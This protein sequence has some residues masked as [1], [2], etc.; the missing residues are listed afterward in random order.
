MKKIFFLSLLILPLV[1]CENP[2]EGSDKKP[3]PIVSEVEA[4]DFEPAISDTTLIYDLGEFTSEVRIKCPKTAFRGTILVLQGWNFPN[5]SWSDST[6][7]E[8]L[9]DANGFVLVMPDMGKSIY[10]KENYPETRA[11]WRKYPTRTWLMDTMIQGL[12]NEFN[13]FAENGPNFV[14][15]LSTGGRGAFILAQENPNI[16][17]AG[18]SLS[19]DYDQSAFPE[20]NLY[21]GF[22][23]TDSTRWH[24]DENPVSFADAWSVPMYIGHGEADK[25]VPVKHAER[26]QEVFSENTSDLSGWKFSYVSDAGHNYNYWSSCTEEVYEFLREI[27]K[28]FIIQ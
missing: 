15:G 19:G 25:I 27:N 6:D 28:K 20:D 17:R 24:D 16:F 14:M 4:V 10:H 13:L 3:D 9:A 2:K 11:D 26:L 7:I 23:G 8:K 1:G 5:T 12:Q 18:A 22:F 21:R